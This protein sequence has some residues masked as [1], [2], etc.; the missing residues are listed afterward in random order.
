MIYGFLYT[1]SVRIRIISPIV[2]CNYMSICICINR[3]G[4]HKD[5]P[6]VYC[7]VNWS[8]HYQIIKLIIDNKYYNLIYKYCKYNRFK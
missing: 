1:E 3:R 6:I 4:I 5:I 2:Y 8:I 7:M